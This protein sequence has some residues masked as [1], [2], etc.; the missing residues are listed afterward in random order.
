M[1]NTRNKA[2]KSV[3]KG[4]PRVTKVK[5]SKVTIA[6]QN[7][8]NNV[9]EVEANSSVEET[10]TPYERLYNKLQEKKRKMQ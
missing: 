4:S 9:N 5:G 10:E 2:A 3:K 7:K 8:Q 6:K 1:P